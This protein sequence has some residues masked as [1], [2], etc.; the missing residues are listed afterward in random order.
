MNWNKNNT[1][2]AFLVFRINDLSLRKE[3][4]KFLNIDDCQ[5]NSKVYEFKKIDTNRPTKISIEVYF[6]YKNHTIEEL[7]KI[8]NQIMKK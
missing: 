3:I 5:L 8:S 2:L 1:L 4:L 7:L 6:E